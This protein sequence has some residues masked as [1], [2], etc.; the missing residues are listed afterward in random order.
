MRL[1]AATVHSAVAG[2]LFFLGIYSGTAAVT[3]RI[4]RDGPADTCTYLHVHVLSE[5]ISRGTP[6]NKSDLV[7][8]LR[9][10]F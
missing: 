8:D 7:P 6:Q 10:W 3:L 5:L 4:R 1:V 9:F 2:G